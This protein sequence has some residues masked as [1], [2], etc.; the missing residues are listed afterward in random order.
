VAQLAG[1][2][3]VV[4]ERA[5]AILHNLQT[6]EADASERIVFGDARPRPRRDVQLGLFAPPPPSATL[7]ALRGLDLDRLS[8]MEALVR[9]AELQKQARAEPP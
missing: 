7:E 5:R 4:V 1:V 2:T 6:K 8:P 3:D 9:L